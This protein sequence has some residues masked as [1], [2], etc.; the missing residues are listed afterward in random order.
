VGECAG[1]GPVSR[2]KPLTPVAREASTRI[3]DA[4]YIAYPAAIKFLVWG[5]VLRVEGRYV[6]AAERTVLQ[7]LTTAFLDTL[8]AETNLPGYTIC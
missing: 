1:V 6:E 4:P 2:V 8:D 5:L 3:V 7:M